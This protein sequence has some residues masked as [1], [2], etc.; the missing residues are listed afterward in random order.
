VAGSRGSPPPRGP[1]PAPAGVA[2]AGAPPRVTGLARRDHRGRVRDLAGQVVSLGSG[3]PAPHAPPPVPVEH[4]QAGGPVRL[5][6]AAAVRAQSRSSGHNRGSVHDGARAPAPRQPRTYRVLAALHAGQRHGDRR[7][8]YRWRVPWSGVGRSG[9]GGTALAWLIAG[10]RRGT[11]G[12]RRWGAQR[13]FERRPGPGHAGQVH[14]PLPRAIGLVVR[15]GPATVVT[16][17]HLG[18][19]ERAHTERLRRTPVR[20]HGVPPGTPTGPAP[21]AAPRR[22]V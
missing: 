17:R 18:Q 7:S 20:S 13:P 6:V 12:R 22:P 14:P 8:W 15:Q 4:H 19:R 9:N 3:R 5:A 21:R 10:R 2:L 11:S 16:V 1:G